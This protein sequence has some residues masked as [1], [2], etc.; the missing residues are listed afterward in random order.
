MPFALDFVGF[1]TLCAFLGFE[2]QRPQGSP[3][4]EDHNFPHSYSGWLQSQS[5][6]LVSSPT[7]RELHA[8]RH[9]KRKGC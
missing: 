9:E 4:P 1:L 7:L 3:G 5:L 6:Q 2:I 8:H